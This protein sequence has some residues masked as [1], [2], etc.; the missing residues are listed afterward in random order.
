MNFP[1][2]THKFSPSFSTVNEAWRPVDVTMNDTI[3]DFFEKD[4]PNSVAY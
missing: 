4:R 3:A 2:L 1:Y